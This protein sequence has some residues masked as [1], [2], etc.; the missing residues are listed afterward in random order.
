MVARLHSCCNSLRPL[1]SSLSSDGLVATP[2]LSAEAFPFAAELE[3]RGSERQ[4]SIT[5]KDLV[6]HA[7][8]AGGLHDRL[9]APPA[10]PPHFPPPEPPASAAARSPLQHLHARYQHKR[11]HAS[12]YAAQ[13]L[14]GSSQRRSDALRGFLGAL[15]APVPGALAL[16][17]AGV[18]GIQRSSSPGPEPAERMHS[19]ALR[20]LQ[21]AA[22]T[23]YVLQQ[24]LTFRPRGTGALGVMRLDLPCR[25]Q[26]NAATGLQLGQVHRSCPF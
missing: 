5:P 16:D 11:P 8:R 7:A 6:A 21:P 12:S 4:L 18:E 9:S 13:A 25:F 14:A 23:R 26:S 10:Q 20:S 22:G 15:S 24:P 17:D 2:F 3:S 1:D 19:G